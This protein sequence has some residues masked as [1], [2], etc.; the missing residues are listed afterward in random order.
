MVFFVLC[1]EGDVTLT[2]LDSVLRAHH[3]LWRVVDTFE[4]KTIVMPKKVRQKHLNILNRTS[5]THTVSLERR[6]KGR[7]MDG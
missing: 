2:V 6:Q 1:L 4:G 7:S 5:L 3:S